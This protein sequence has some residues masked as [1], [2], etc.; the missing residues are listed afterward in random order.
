MRPIDADALEREYRRQ[1]ESVYKH[2]RDT[3]LPSDFYIERKAA[4][5]RELVRMEM[6]AFCEFL[7]S[8]PTIDAEPVRHGWWIVEDIVI[9]NNGRT[10]PDWPRCSECD[11]Q[12]DLEYD[13]CPNCGAKM[14]EVVLHAEKRSDP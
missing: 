8:R 11:R 13:Y 5:D 12:S 14:D 9:D 3:V 10:M 2:T 7:K 6:E 4:Y 1:F